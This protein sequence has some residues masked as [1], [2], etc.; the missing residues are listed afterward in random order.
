MFDP[1]TIISANPWIQIHHVRMPE[2]KPGATDGKQ[3]IWLDKRLTARE[4]RCVLT[5]ELVHL[6]YGHQD[7]Q[8]M[9][10]ERKVRREAA[11]L[12]VPWPSLAMF[13]HADLPSLAEELN[14]TQLVLEDRLHALSPLEVSL[15]RERGVTI[16]ADV[17]W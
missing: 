12:L 2:G 6:Q 16:S 15:L 3:V 10:I 8:A 14:V 17:S 9:K 13:E 4:R 7:C 5:H 1:W 11:H